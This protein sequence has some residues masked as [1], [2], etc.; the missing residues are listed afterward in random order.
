MHC[1]FPLNTTKTVAFSFDIKEK[2]FCA[3]SQG[4]KPLAMLFQLLW[5]CILAVCIRIIHLRYTDRC[6]NS[7]KMQVFCSIVS[8]DR[9]WIKKTGKTNYYLNSASQKACSETLCVSTHTAQP[10][11]TASASACMQ[12][13]FLW[14]CCPGNSPLTSIKKF[15]YTVTTQSK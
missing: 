8:F 7:C 4:Q 9:A 2:S 3:Y 1:P 13:I 6:S 11:A 15:Q 10:W 14:G 5:T 12:I